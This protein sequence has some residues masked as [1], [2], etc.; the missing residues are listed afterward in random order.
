[1]NKLKANLEGVVQLQVS[2]KAILLE[3][4]SNFTSCLRSSQWRILQY[5]QSS[6]SL[7]FSL[8]ELYG[9]MK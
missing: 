3:A 8:K 1:M 6:K 4:F 5:K 7:G 9:F 2:Y